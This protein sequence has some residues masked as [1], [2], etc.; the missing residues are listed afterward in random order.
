MTSRLFRQE[1][2]EAQ[3][4][5][6]WS[7]VTLTTPLPLKL[8][9]GA[10]LLSVAGLA[11]YLVTGSFSHKEHAPGFIAAHEGVANVM[12]P[13]AGAV[14]ELFV[15]EGQI[16]NKGDPLLSVR[17]EQTN[18]S[19]IGV[20]AAEM[21]SLRRENTQIRKQIDLENR[22]ADAAAES[23]KAAIV[24]IDAEIATLKQQLAVQ[25]QKTAM[26][27]QA[28]SEVAPLVA[29]HLITQPE[30]AKRREALLTS[31]QAEL[32]LNRAIAARA[33]DRNA[34]SAEL[35]QL[36]IESQQRIA[37]LRGE[38]DENRLKI[39]QIDADRGYVVNAPKDGKVSALQVWVGKTVETNVPQM[40]IVPLNDTL[41]A[42]LFVPAQAIGLIAPGQ[43]VHLDLASF[44]YQKFGFLEGAVDTVSYTLLKPDQSVGP[45]ALAAPAYRV[46]V[47]LKQQTIRA[48]GQDV[49]LKSD[50]QLSADIVSDRRSLFEWIIDPLLAALRRS[51]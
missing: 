35:T 23:L 19:G 38:K 37:V 49:A 25:A 50:M 36:P 45:I 14:A 51:A 11:A 12:A 32:E 24:S 21:K 43:P 46:S 48:Y 39:S 5:R 2:I 6:L 18:L 47:T 29:K 10:L 17:Y 3:S 1:A 16:V 7:D 22:K 15:R 27:S 28:I 13:R 44:P 30:Q 9:A 26:A 41:T 42:E 33:T 40:S 8:A 20:D 4:S 34:K 31:Q